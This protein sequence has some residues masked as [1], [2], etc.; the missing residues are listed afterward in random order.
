[1]RP[2]KDSDRV[3]VVFYFIL[4][5][6][7]GFWFLCLNWNTPFMHDDLAYHYYYDENSAVERPTSEPISSFWQIFPSMWNHYNAVNGRFTSHFII[8]LFCGILGKQIFNYLNTIVFLLLIDL[9]VV[10]SYGK[11]RLLPLAIVVTSVLFLLPFP[12]QTML[13]L[14]GSVNYMWSAAFSLI[15]LKIVLGKI[16][17]GKL[18]CLVSFLFCVFAGWMNESITF[19]IGGGLIVYA[20]LNHNRFKGI[21]RWT[22]IGYLIGCLML[23]LS[24]GTL[25]RASSGEINTELD[26]LQMFSSRI[27]SS[28]FIFKSL[29]IIA[30]AWLIVVLACFKR[31]KVLFRDQSLIIFSFVLSALFCFLIGLPESR[32]FF[33]VSVLSTILLISVI[34]YLMNSVAVPNFALRSVSIIFLALCISPALKAINKTSWYCQHS[35]EVESCIKASPMACVIEACPVSDSRFVYAT[36]VTGNRY[37]FHNRV[38]SFFYHKD[39]VCAVPKPLYSSYINQ[40]KTQIPSEYLVLQLDDTT[41]AIKG[42]KGHHLKTGNLSRKQHIVRYLLGTLDDDIVISDYAILDYN[43]E[44]LLIVP[45]NEAIDRLIITLANHDIIEVPCE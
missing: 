7:V 4:L 10:L 2:K 24:P 26:I 21:I 11:R 32:V 36:K 33:G 14:T 9:I 3:E 8:Q 5:A 6:L 12:G 18:L 42:I 23:L 39:Y 28:V 22:I 37:Q 43:T 38:R 35:S 20:F 30:I 40:D 34:R 1:M 45:R 19:G 16:Y 15:V 29:P 17:N 31:F 25:N 27:L 44:S 41:R 13:W